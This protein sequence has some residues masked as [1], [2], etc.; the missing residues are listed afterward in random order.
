MG[1]WCSL[2]QNSQ[3][4]GVSLPFSVYTLTSYLMYQCLF[5]D[6]LNY[7]FILQ[8]FECQLFARVGMC[9]MKVI[10]YRAPDVKRHL[11]QIYLLSNLIQPQVKPLRLCAAFTAFSWLWQDQELPNGTASSSLAGKSEAKLSL[12]AVRK[13]WLPCRTGMRPASSS[14]GVP[15]WD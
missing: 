3:I 1:Q 4:Y 13:H 8:L 2:S 9:K 14:L 15:V 5:W 12:V 7:L 6:S 10:P 11:F